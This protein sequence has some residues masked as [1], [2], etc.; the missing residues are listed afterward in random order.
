[1][2]LTVTFIEQGFSIHRVGAEGPEFYIEQDGKRIWVEAIAPGPGVG[3]DRVPEPELGVAYHVPTE[4]ILLRFTHAL[5]EKRKKYIAARKKGI[6]SPD[7]GYLLAI[8]SRGIPHAPYGNT[9]PYFI[10][11]YL[12]FGPYAISIDSGTGNIVESF[13][14]H[15]E[16]VSKLNGENIPTT[17]F[18]DREFSCIS[19]VLH[20]SVDCVNRPATLGGDFSMLH[21]PNAS[22]GVNQ[23]LF[24]WCQQFSLVGDELITRESN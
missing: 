8:N 1:M 2:Y 11:A 20:S 18:L 9:M 5:S 17:A 15:R 19:S 4:K 14:Q 24:G 12:P 10:Q 3:P 23:S 7:D 6:I 22:L 21:N 13:Y 16:T